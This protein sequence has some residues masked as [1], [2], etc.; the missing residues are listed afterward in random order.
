MR[1]G[2]KT[3]EFV[4]L[5][6]TILTAIFN[7]L[8]WVNFPA[9][10]FTVVLVWMI[11]RIGEKT[12]GSVDANGKRAWQTSEFWVSI[13]VAGVCYVFPDVNQELIYTAYA[14]I[15]GRPLVKVT[16]NF[17]ISDVVNK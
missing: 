7:G 16:K 15:V 14:W 8:G 11:A 13:I 9:E 6:V 17:N 1:T 12:L 10:S 3:T 4:T 2:W 5:G